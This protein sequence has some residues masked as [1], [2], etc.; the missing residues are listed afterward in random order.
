MTPCDSP[1]TK[2]EK[3]SPSE[4]LGVHFLLFREEE[5]AIR[6]ENVLGKREVEGMKNT[7]K[8]DREVD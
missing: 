4:R 2:L 7:R 5:E 6:A 1:Y 8:E 3:P